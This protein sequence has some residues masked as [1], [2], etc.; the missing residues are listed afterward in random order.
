MASST[1]PISS[2]GAI[3]VPTFSGSST[4]S[5][6]FQNVLTNAVNEASIPMEQMQDGVT[7]L[8]NQQSAL[9]QLESTF[10]SLDASLQSIG[11]A[12]GG[13]PSASVSN[14]AVLSASTTSSALAGTYS[15]E[16]S[17]LG[18]NSTAI[19]AAG[20]TPVTDP[21]T[22]NISSASTF[23]LTVN[24][25]D[26]TITPANNTL[27][28]LASAIN[29]SPAGIQA[30]IVNLGSD[31]SPDY[32]LVVTSNNLA[33]DAITLSDGTSNLLSAVTPGAPATYSVNGSPE[34]QST[35]SQV[36]LSPG[37]TVNLLGTSATP[38]TIS[39]STNYTALQSALSSFATAYNAAVT[40]VNAQIGQN[41]GPL[42]GD[43]LISTLQSALKNVSQYSSGSGTVSSLDEL[44]LTVDET[45]TMSFDSATFSALN[46]AD[47]AQFLGASTTGG[48]MQAAS[49]A[50]S[51]VDNETT[52]DIEGDYSAL[53]TQINHQNQLIASEQ[54]RITDMETNLQSQLSQADAAIA[55]LQS[56]KTYYAD[57]F[58]AEFPSST[59]E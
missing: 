4:F 26:T 52:G 1:S 51:S 19:S 43:S 30:T 14:S 15:I 34:V 57:L 38:V 42:S 36:T 41:A 40:A 55:T 5:S 10:Q 49:N 20:S 11:A 21:T 48:F 33:A 53:Q 39:V 58:Q 8:T 45:G 59:S 7:T 47:V 31:N 50:L 16:V 37:L 9:T 29:S 35:S 6:A 12:T 24:G 28:G 27:E 22:Q 2:T 56:Q 44:G 13:S 25:T 18:S 23:T 3:N 32:R 46:P 17:S 54:I